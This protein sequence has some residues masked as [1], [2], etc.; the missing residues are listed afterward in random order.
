MHLRDLMSDLV[1][2]SENRDTEERTV[3]P[4]ASMAPIRCPLGSIQCRNGDECILHDHMCDGEPDCRDGSDEDQCSLAC[5]TG[6][7][8]VWGEEGRDQTPLVPA[9]VAAC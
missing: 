2:S 8:Q 6:N 9:S 5:D 3:A 4:A 7:L 1:S